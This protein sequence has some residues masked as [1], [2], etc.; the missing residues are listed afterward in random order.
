MAYTGFKK[1]LTCENF[2]TPC[3]FDGNIKRVIQLFKVPLKI[4]RQNPTFAK[5][6]MSFGNAKEFYNYKNSVNR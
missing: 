4:R 1:P 3:R 6:A 5:F 2:A